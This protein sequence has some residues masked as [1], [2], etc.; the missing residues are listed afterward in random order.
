MF[1]N[2]QFIG[3][4]VGLVLFV[5]LVAILAVICT[6]RKYAG[7]LGS[8]AG[9]VKFQEEVRLAVVCTLVIHHENMPI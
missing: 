6:R 7:R 5:I 3:L 1:T 8:Q 4:I 2:S 9:A